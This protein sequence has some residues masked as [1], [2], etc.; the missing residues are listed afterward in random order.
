VIVPVTGFTSTLP[1]VGGVAIATLVG[2]IAPSA[3]V[4]FAS[5]SMTTLPPVGTGAVSACAVGG[6]FG[7]CEQSGRSVA[8]SLAARPSGS[9]TVKVKRQA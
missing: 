1:E 6:S 9:V 5:T 7:S 2:S 3:S 4:S 8:V